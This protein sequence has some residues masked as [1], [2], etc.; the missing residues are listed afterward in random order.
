M[1]FS[2]YFL[3]GRQAKNLK[4]KMT[5]R[6][7]T[8]LKNKQIKSRKKTL[9]NHAMWNK[10]RKD[11]KDKQLHDGMGHGTVEN[12]ETYKPVNVA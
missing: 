8:I 9:N 6:G 12:N 5:T 4:S 10:R 1:T 2:K 3:N 7:D 11:L